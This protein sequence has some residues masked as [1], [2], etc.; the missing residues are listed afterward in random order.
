MLFFSFVL[1]CWTVAVLLPHA[2][3]S[4]AFAVAVV[5]AVLTQVAIAG[6]ES[7]GSRPYSR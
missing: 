2:A 4:V 5:D 3:A 7:I 6:G 1:F